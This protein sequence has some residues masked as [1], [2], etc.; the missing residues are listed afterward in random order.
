MALFVRLVSVS[1]LGGV[2]FYGFFC[3]LF[4]PDRISWDGLN[5]Q[6]DFDSFTPSPNWQELLPEGGMWCSVVHASFEALVN[7]RTSLL[8]DGI[9]FKRGPTGS[10]HSFNHQGDR[11]SHFTSCQTLPETKDV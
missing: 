5:Q 2:R 1:L 11:L 7:E 3:F 10:D 6:P 9:A 4:H 8:V